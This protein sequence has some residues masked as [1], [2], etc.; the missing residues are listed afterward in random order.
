MHELNGTY[1]LKFNQRHERVGHLLQGRFKGILVCKETHLLELTRYIVLN[2]VRAG[3]VAVPEAWPWSNYSATAG[4]SP[5]PNWLKVEWTRHQFSSEESTATSAYIDFVAAGGKIVTHPFRDLRS[6]IFLGDDN[7]RCRMRDEISRVLVSAEVPRA[8]REIEDVSLES[9]VRETARAT[10]TGP[11]SIRC[12]RGGDARLL[13]ATLA[14]QLALASLRDIAS[15]LSIHAS[16]VSRLAAEG[17]R[18]LEQDQSLRTKADRV[19]SRLRAPAPAKA[20]GK[21]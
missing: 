4:L 1:A 21:T 20:K 10:G 16:R 8:Q 6:Q 9:L 2:P 14:R 13:V 11:E 5:R 19:L 3:L 17:S 15:A 12:G 7:F 18:R